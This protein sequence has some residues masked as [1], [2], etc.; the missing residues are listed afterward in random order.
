MVPGWLIWLFYMNHN[1]WH[2]CTCRLLFTTTWICNWPVTT[3]FLIQGV[4]PVFYN[5]NFLGC[6]IRSCFHEE[7]RR[8]HFFTGWNP[9]QR[10]S[11]F[12]PSVAVTHFACPQ[13][14]V[15]IIC[16][17]WVLGSKARNDHLV[18]QD[19]FF[20]LI[21]DLQCWDFKGLMSLGV[22]YAKDIES[23]AFLAIIK[24]ATVTRPDLV[25]PGPTEYF[26]T[27]SGFFSGFG[28]ASE[29]RPGHP[30]G[31]N[32]YW[33]FRPYM[34]MMLGKTLSLS[35]ISYASPTS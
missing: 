10:T 34:L 19:I 21:I 15:H 4:L 35:H 1:R 25:T 26:K 18:C 23:E 22:W 6:V 2:I 16:R 29:T 30:C 32:S 5:V 9:S 12:P 13:W 27:A 28:P 3:S 33:T 8:V 31:H 20:Q 24:P 17:C 14:S 7:P 11:H